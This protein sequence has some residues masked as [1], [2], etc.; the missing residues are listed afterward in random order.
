M[1]SKKEFLAVKHNQAEIVVS[2]HGEIVLVMPG[3]QS[4]W[5]VVTNAVLNCEEKTTEINVYNLMA[6]VKGGGS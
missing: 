1:E 5:E 4:T 6:T 3:H 2:P